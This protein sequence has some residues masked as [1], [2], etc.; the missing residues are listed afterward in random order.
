MPTNDDT[1]D[2]TR[3][4]AISA[5]T[6]AS[7]EIETNSKLYEIDAIDEKDEGRR[8]NKRKNERKMD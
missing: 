4:S 5:S 8:R 1:V 2:C 6:S 3:S 7:I